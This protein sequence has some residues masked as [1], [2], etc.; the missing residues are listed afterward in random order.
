M[1][2]RKLISAVCFLLVLNERSL[3][4]YELR[5][6]RRGM[7]VSE[8]MVVMVVVMEGNCSTRLHFVWYFIFLT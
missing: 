2:Q 7:V 3:I 8:N 5:D 6:K 4:L 1:Q